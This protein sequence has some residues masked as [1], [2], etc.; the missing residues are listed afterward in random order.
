MIAGIL[1][2]VATGSA[3]YKKFKKAGKVLSAVSGFFW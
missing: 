2:A 3:K 1:S